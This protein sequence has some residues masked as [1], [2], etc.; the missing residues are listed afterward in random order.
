MATTI[1]DFHFVTSDF[2][3]ARPEDRV[4]LTAPVAL[5]GPSALARFVSRG[6][7][8]PDLI[9]RILKHGFPGSFNQ[10]RLRCGSGC[11][12][13]PIKTGKE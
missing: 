10:Q 7:Y 11:V 12:G 9:G 4:S 6:A 8:S 3:D 2:L 1:S 5:C 13:A